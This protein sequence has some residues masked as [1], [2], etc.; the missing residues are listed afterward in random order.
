MN[1]D[2]LDR[3]VAELERRHGDLRRVADQSGVPYD[4]VLRV[5]NREN[6][7]TYSRIKRL[8]DYLFQRQ[9]A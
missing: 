9:A 3:V 1:D 8:A 2:L 4:T 6:D 5:K 7:P